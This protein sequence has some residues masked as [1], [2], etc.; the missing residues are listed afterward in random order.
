MMYKCNCENVAIGSYCN[1]VELKAPNWAGKDII[2]V[3]A[4]LAAEIEVL[5]DKGIKT[6]GCCCGH[7]RLEPYIGVYYEHIEEMKKM[8]YENIKYI[9]GCAWPEVH[10]IAE[11]LR[12]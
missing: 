9:K 12:V 1:Q 8:G 3:D 5:W 7:N 11:S 4:C 6:N 10:F 2:C